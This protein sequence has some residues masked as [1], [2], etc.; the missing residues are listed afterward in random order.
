MMVMKI[1]KQKKCALK[2]SLQFQDYK[3]CLK[4]NQLANEMNYLENNIQTDSLSENNKDFI[5]N[6]RLILKSQQRFKSEKHNVFS[7]EVNKIALSTDDDK[8]KQSNQYKH[9]L[10]EQVKIKN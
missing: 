2:Q 10:M 3:N 4:E 9:V 6:N 1:K 8:R 5:E 7:E